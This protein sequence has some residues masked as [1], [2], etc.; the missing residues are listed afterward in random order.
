LLR[1]LVRLLFSR[2]LEALAVSNQV[3]T[4]FEPSLRHP[5]LDIENCGPETGPKNWPLLAGNSENYGSETHLHL[6]NCRD[7][8]RIAANRTW[9]TETR[10]GQDLVLVRRRNRHRQGAGL[11]SQ[12]LGH[13]GE[14]EM[15]GQPRSGTVCGINCSRGPERTAVRDGG[16]TFRRLATSRKGQRSAKSDPQAEVFLT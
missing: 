7:L 15:D 1:E 3:S 2:D 10:L 11:V 14:L 9:P 12:S 16:G 13:Q 5:N 8:A 6:A 4:E